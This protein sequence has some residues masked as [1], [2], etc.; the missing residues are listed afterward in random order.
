MESS[1]SNNHTQGGGGGSN[2]P[3]HSVPPH[4]TKARQSSASQLQA[5]L[6]LQHM[7]QIQALNGYKTS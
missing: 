3:R 7:K 2:L 4:S 6:N 1:N 5:Q